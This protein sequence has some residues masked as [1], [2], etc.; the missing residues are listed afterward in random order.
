MERGKKAI[1]LFGIHISVR[2]SQNRLSL[3]FKDIL[4]KKLFCHKAFLVLLDINLMPFSKN[5]LKTFL[6]PIW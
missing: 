2:K 3:C 1:S 6:Y 4:K 5:C